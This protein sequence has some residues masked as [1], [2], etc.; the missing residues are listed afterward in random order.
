MRRC[1]SANRAHRTR[2]GSCMTVQAIIP[3]PEELLEQIERGNVL[4]FVG[5]HSAHD[6]AG[7]SVPNQLSKA[8]AA[9]L[10]IDDAEDLSF[11]QLAQ[12]YEDEKGRHALVQLIRDQ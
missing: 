6:L 7:Q 9:R 12:A 10:G 1:S 11:P 2:K 3:I 4:L 8:L 5:E